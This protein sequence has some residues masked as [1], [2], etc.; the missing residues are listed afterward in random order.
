M[1]ISKPVASIILVLLFQ[2]LG[3]DPGRFGPKS[4]PRSGPVLT[5]A[6][7]LTNRELVVSAPERLNPSPT[8]RAVA[9]PR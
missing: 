2:L 9:S 7:A 5:V 4:G 6:I 3:L 1:R 8:L